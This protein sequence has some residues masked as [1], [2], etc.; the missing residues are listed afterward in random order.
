MSPSADKQ[1][2]MPCWPQGGGRGCPVSV[3]C[4]PSGRQDIVRHRRCVPLTPFLLQDG[5]ARHLKSD[6]I[7]ARV[8]PPISR[9]EASSWTALLSAFVPPPSCPGLAGSQ[10]R[11]CCRRRA[12]SQPAEMEPGGGRDSGAW[13]FLSVEKLHHMS[14]TANN[15]TTYRWTRRMCR[16]TIVI[17]QRLDQ[18]PWLP[19]SLPQQPR[20]Q[21]EMRGFLGSISVNLYVSANPPK[22]CTSTV[23][24]DNPFVSVPVGAAPRKRQGDMEEPLTWRWHNGGFS[25]TR[26]RPPFCV[27]WTTT[28]GIR[29][30]GSPESVK[31]RLLPRTVAS[32]LSQVR[33]AT[34]RLAMQSP[35]NQCASDGECRCNSLDPASRTQCCRD[36]V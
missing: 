15:S 18:S 7:Q 10:N 4:L 1:A 6:E 26:L 9:P 2:T 30:S 35:W 19:V 14:E 5:S 31:P 24:F 25:K 11:A 20:L 13:C 33:A 21:L 28:S 12:P 29:L 34:R 16:G 22:W 27:L 36:V 32:W 8:M 17:D 23:D 3:V